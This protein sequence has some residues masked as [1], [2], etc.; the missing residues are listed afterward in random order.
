M[1]IA[2]ASAPYVTIRHFEG[3]TGYTAKA[4]ER[5]IADGVWLENEV[6]VRAPDG[7]ILIRMAGYV[8]WVEGGKAAA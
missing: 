2:V 8:A 4:V 7:R 1:P 6:W 5:K 3:A